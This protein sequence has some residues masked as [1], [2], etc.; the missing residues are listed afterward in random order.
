MN[1]NSSTSINSSDSKNVID[2]KNSIADQNSLKSNQNDDID[3]K[4]EALIESNEVE[5]DFI[6]E[7]N[8]ENLKKLGIDR[9]SSCKVLVEFK[10]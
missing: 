6:D 8:D 5:N 3:G 9:T 2:C 4:D 10:R 1:G 7:F